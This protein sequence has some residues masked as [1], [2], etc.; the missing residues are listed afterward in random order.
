ML[1][2]GHHLCLLL[3]T[4]A[5]LWLSHAYSLPALRAI[6]FEIPGAVLQIVTNEATVHS[7]L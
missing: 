2:L 7:L 5:N 4:S 1:Q 6:E 3:L